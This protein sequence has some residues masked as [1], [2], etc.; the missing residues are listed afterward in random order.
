MSSFRLPRLT[1]GYKSKGAASWSACVASEIVLALVRVCAAKPPFSRPCGVKI[2]SVSSPFFARLRN[3]STKTLRAH[4]L[5]GAMKLV[6]SSATIFCNGRALSVV[7]PD[8]V[9]IP[10]WNPATT[11]A[12]N[13]SISVKSKISTAARIVESKLNRHSIVIRT[14][15]TD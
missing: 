11:N 9:Q 8:Y 4:R 7:G 10:C 14:Y 6:K 1:R 2:Q 13:F 3:S 12:R 5:Q 15:I